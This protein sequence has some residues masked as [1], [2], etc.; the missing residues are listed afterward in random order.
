MW[1]R[2]ICFCLFVAA[3]MGFTTSSAAVLLEGRNGT[4]YPRPKHCP[5]SSAASS[6]FWS[7][8]LQAIEKVT[9]LER[10]TNNIG[11]ITTPRFPFGSETKL[12]KIGRLGWL[13]V[14]RVAI[15]NAPKQQIIP[16][17]ECG[18][19]DYS[20]SL[21]QTQHFAI[22]QI[23]G[24]INYLSRPD[25]KAVIISRVIH[26]GSTS[27][28][29]YIQ[30]SGMRWSKETRHQNVDRGGPS[31]VLDSHINVEAAIG[32]Q[33]IIRDCHYKQP[34]ASI[35]S[36]L[37]NLILHCSGDAFHG[38]SRTGGLGN[39]AIGGSNGSIGRNNGMLSISDSFSRCVPKQASEE[40]QASSG[41]K[42]H[43][44]KYCQPPVWTRIPIALFLGLGSNG[45][46]VV[47]LLTLDGRWRRWGVGL[48]IVAVTMFLGGGALLFSLAYPAT[49]GWWI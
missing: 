4:S 39:M 1:A 19:V 2:V 16:G 41:E 22:V 38:G 49:W 17:L 21:S 3:F 20:I 29:S 26:V 48:C 30:Y 34:S 12:R 47:G 33:T 10:Y 35:R 37:A 42:E 36:Y 27:S 15:S 40:P 44:G 24:L 45:V 11:G 13:I 46:L 28:Q 9:L 43:A 31:E 8:S 14:Q 25:K 5:M 7:S 32:V 6:L 23:N 18:V